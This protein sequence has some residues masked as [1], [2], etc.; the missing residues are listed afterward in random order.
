[1]LILSTARTPSPPPL[2]TSSRV[3]PSPL[4]FITHYVQLI[5]QM[6]C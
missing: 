2:D 1:M 3:F 5:L 4:I 6:K